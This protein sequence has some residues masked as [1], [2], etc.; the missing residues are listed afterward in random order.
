[1]KKKLNKITE[2]IK[3]ARYSVAQ[4]NKHE[5]DQELIRAT[6]DLQEAARLLKTIKQPRTSQSK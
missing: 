1:M 6:Q 2:L 4:W 3:N 5:Q